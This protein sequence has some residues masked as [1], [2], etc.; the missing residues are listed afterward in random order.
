MKDWLVVKNIF[1]NEVLTNLTIFLNVNEVSS[2]TM[3]LANWLITYHNEVVIL[4]D[5]V[6]Q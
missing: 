3:K 4:V 5:N 2:S 1:D 6:S